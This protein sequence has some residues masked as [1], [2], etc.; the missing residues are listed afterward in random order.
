MK[1]KRRHWFTFEVSY[2]SCFYLPRSL[3]WLPAGN[4]VKLTH[5]LQVKSLPVYPPTIFAVLAPT[6][7][8]HR[9]TAAHSPITADCSPAFFKPACLVGL[10]LASGNLG[11]GRI[12]ILAATVKRGSLGLCRTN[13]M[14][15]AEPLL[16]FWESGIQANA[17][18]RVLMWP[19]PRENLGQG[20]AM[21][22]PCTQLFTCVLQL[23]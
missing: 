8:L 19:A 11:V 13:S 22:V 6:V 21:S 5:V 12:P 7:C 18:Q 17:R 23:T 20:I 1:K 2:S 4:S 15:H 16:S 9:Q 14:V 3:Q 10:R